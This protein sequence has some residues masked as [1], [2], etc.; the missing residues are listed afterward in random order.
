MWVFVKKVDRGDDVQL[1][2]SFPAKSLSIYKANILM[3]PL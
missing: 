2:S 3:T 1:F